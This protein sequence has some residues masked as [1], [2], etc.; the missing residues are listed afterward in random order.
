MSI[1]VRTLLLLL[2]QNVS[3]ILLSCLL[4]QVQEEREVYKKDYDEKSRE[5]NRLQE[6][7]MAKTAMVKQYEKQQQGD[8][9]EIEKVCV[10]ENMYFCTH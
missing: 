5:V 1:E 3:A 7:V 6:E 8:S 2:F 10:S 4:L 9:E